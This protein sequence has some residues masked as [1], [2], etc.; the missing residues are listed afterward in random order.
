[1]PEMPD[2]IL[3]GETFFIIEDIPL[4][5]PDGLDSLTMR[6][7]TASRDTFAGGGA[8]PE[9]PLMRIKEDEVRTELPGEAYEHRLQCEGLLADNKEE[10]ETV[11]MP[12]EGWDE[13]TR[14]MLTTDD[15]V[16]AHDSEHPDHEHMIVK[17]RQVDPIAAGIYRVT[18]TY[19]GILE[20]KTP[21]R[22]FTC[23]AKEIQS[24]TAYAITG[25]VGGTDQLWVTPRQRVG[26][27]ERFLFI[28]DPQDY[29][30]LI[31]QELAGGDLP[32]NVPTIAMSPVDALAPNKKYSFPNGWRVE[33]VNAVPLERT[34]TE[35]DITV[36]YAFV[37]VT[38]PTGLTQS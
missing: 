24:E 5:R 37:P 20:I 19:A 6:V 1:M 36:R 7:Q 21:K 15:T 26:F 4:L 11:R 2:S 16:M 29:Y 34:R 8:P 14:V 33:S 31:G 25:E 13:I 30:D 27:T 22:Q 28:G 3:Y 38:E 10:P 9:Y 18:A 17:G 12:D 35:H 23:D 32:S